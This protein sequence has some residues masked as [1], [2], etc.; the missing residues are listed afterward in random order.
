MLKSTIRDGSDAIPDP[1]IGA[2][3]CQIAV[4][5][6]DRT[7]VLGVSGTL[8]MVTAPR[9]TESIQTALDSE[10]TAV[11]IDLTGVEFLASAGM[12]VLIAAHE[13]IGGSAQ[14]VAVADGPVTAR[15]LRLV[16]L[17]KLLTIHPTL[18]EALEASAGK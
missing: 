3:G 17:D 9:L 13:R 14:L 16:G 18:D 5:R 2:G 4:T 12:T 11:I 6:H 7:V 1:G 8:D 15:P 10:P